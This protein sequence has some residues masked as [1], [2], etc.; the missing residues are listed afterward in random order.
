MRNALNYMQVFRHYTAIRASSVGAKQLISFYF[1]VWPFQTTVRKTNSLA[2]TKYYD[3]IL[4]KGSY[5]PCLR[6]AG[7]DFLAGYPRLKGRQP[8]IVDVI[9][10]LVF[11]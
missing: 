2:W 9:Q 11:S 6:M 7:R 3:G 8:V 4:P 1:G 5:P 10:F